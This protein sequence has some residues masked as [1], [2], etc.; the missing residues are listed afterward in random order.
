MPTEPLSY[1]HYEIQTD[2]SGSPLRLGAGGMGTTYRA[3]DTR[4]KR[5]VALK[6]I[7]NTKFHN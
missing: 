7:N 1:E 2:E 6:I 5:V 3:F 4:L